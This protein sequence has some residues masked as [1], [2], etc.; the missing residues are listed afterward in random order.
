MAKVEVTIQLKPSLMDA[1]GVTINKALH[2]LGYNEVKGVRIGKFVE[3]EIDGD[4]PADIEVRVREMCEKLLANPI[5]EDYQVNVA[6][7]NPALEVR[8]PRTAHATK[9]RV[10]DWRGFHMSVSEYEA[11]DWKERGN[12][13]AE[14]QQLHG[15]WIEQ[16]MQERGAKW[17]LVV[18]GAVIAFGLSWQDC[19]NSL[20]LG[21]QCLQSQKMHWLFEKL[22]CIEETAWSPLSEGDCYPT[23]S[24][25][26]V[27]NNPSV[28]VQLTADFD[29][30]S[31]A[32]LVGESTLRLAGLLPSRLMLIQ[33][34]SHLGRTFQYASLPLSVLVT[35]ESGNRQVGEVD[36]AIVYGWE[37]SPF[38]SINPRREALVGRN[39]LL[40]LPA[41]IELDGITRHTRITKVS[42]G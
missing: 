25:E 16:Q 15:D 22:L 42:S 2:N 27:G 3:L 6:A 24:L 30:G 41:C 12:L 7:G 29:S 19:P 28:S 34:A 31:N 33:T 5:I 35:D 37:G 20:E 8:E 26:I 23:I 40:S 9:P 18:E 11:L 14:F 13:H 4:K 39:F 1:Q 38:T 17:I 36:G 10:E 21:E 32:T